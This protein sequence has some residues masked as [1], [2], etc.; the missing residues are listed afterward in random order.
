MGRKT[1]SE[2]KRYFL[3]QESFN[4]IGEILIKNFKALF[5]YITK[6]NWVRRK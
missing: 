1:V 6:N 5:F 2:I 4:E 3:K